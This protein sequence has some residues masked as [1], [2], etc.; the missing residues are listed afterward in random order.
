MNNIT[1]NIIFVLLTSILIFSIASNYKVFQVMKAQNFL[2]KDYGKH[3]PEVS[4]KEVLN[5]DFSY[6]NINA[7]TVPFKTYIGRVYLRDSQYQK[8]ISYFHEARKYNPYLKS[9]ENYLAE[10]YDAIKVK[11][12]FQF[13]AKVAYKEMPNNT[14]HFG[15]YIKSIGPHKNSYTVD[16]LFNSQVYKTN[17]FWQLYLSSL[18]S[19]DSKS[20]LAKQNFNKAIELFP[21]D[22]NIETLVDYN[23]YGKENVDKSEQFVR[24]ADELARTDDFIGAIKVLKD[25]IKLYPKNDYYEKLATCYYKLKDYKSTVEYLDRMNLEKTYSI[26]R[27]HLILGVALCELKQNQ[28]GCDELTKA[29]F[30]KDPQALKTKSIYCR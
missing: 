30:S 11:D 12:S 4:L 6:P 28:R 22:K 13:Y 9:S 24:L 21:K 5:Y 10:I 7:Y 17:I 20:Y 27:Y 25:A 19:I 2:I 26:G 1:K 29:V 18:V 23:I 14:L 3:T 15:R 8:A 16:T